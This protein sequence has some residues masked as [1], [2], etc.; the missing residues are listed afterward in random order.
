M[1]R[2]IFQPVG[3][4]VLELDTPALVLDLEAMVRNIE[5]LHFSFRDSA[6]KVRPHV[7]CHQCPNVAWHQLAAEGTVGGIAV[8]TL[9]EAEVFSNAGF[10]DIL[11][12]NEI[13]TRSKIR[14]LCALARQGR[15][16]VA[17]DNPDNVAALS[18]AATTARVTLEVLVDI[19]AGLGRCGVAPGAE[20]VS[21][22]QAASRA[23]GL[24]FRG[25][26]AYEGPLL[27]S[28]RGTLER[29]TRARLQPVL[30]TR[31][32]LERQG[33]PVAVLSVGGTHN[34]DV[35]GAM[36]GVTEVPAGSYVLMDHNYCS[37]RPEFTPAVKLLGSVISHPLDFR[38][39]VDTGHKTVGP[40]LGLPVLEGVT[41]GT[42]T[43]FSAEHGVMELEGAAQQALQPKDK[44]WLVPFDLAMTINQFD[45]FR[46]VRGG[47]LEGFWPISARG[48]FD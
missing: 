2:P 34:Y 41:G 20:A 43:R 23:S 24:D 39:V 5:V 42:A 33:I 28:D 36:A 29:E 25:I 3:T 19:D 46:A 12:T 8:T 9:G 44:V 6:A 48:R 18:E 4:P 10:S 22:A 26:M 7:S 35:A 40:D 32:Q 45:Y 27:H 13:V 31:Q 16:A 30:D 17:V 1:E 15:V 14:R 38:A 11:I 47:Q 21:L 37:Y